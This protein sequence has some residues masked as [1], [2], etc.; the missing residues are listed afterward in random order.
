M[1]AM[2]AKQRAQDLHA[3]GVKPSAGKATSSASVTAYPPES[4]HKRGSTM[5]SIQ[6]ILDAIAQ[7]P[8]FSATECFLESSLGLVRTN[9]SMQ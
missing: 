7:V 3:L 2:Q 5:P 4:R 8:A 6:E 1:R 9:Q